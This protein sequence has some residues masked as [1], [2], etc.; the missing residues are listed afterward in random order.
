M[1]NCAFRAINVNEYAFIC[2]INK[3]TI[4]LIKLSDCIYLLLQFAKMQK[5]RLKIQ[6][7]LYLKRMHIIQGRLLI[8][9]MV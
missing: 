8:A 3:I 2:Q 7:N 9:P 5:F 1:K 6:R 4:R